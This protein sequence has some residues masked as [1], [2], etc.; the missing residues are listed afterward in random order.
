V[1]LPSFQ[2]YPGDWV[3]DP[4][5]RR[6]SHA[7]KGVWID[8]LCLMHESEQRGVLATAGRAWDDDEIALAVGGDRSTVLACVQE[9]IL[10]G[11]AN[12]QSNGAL[13]SRRLVRDE[14]KRL[15][16]VEAGKRG[17]NPKLVRTLKGEG[18]GES[19]GEAKGEA[20]PKPTPSS[21]SSSSSS[22]KNIKTPPT[23][24]GATLPFDDPGF[25]DLWQR[26]LE[27]LKQKKKPP[28]V[29]AIAMQLNKLC[30]MGLER[31]KTTLRHSIT[32]NWQGLFEPKDDVQNAKNLPLFREHKEERD[33][34]PLVS[35]ETWNQLNEQER[36][37]FQLEPAKWK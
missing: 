3:K 31:A 22:D 36:K 29:N 25:V 21:S 14:Q 23:P 7:A 24:K 37:N 4:N 20:N 27:H 5:L 32:N 16:C 9:L 28:T 15:L 2:F 19:K 34:R 13:Y 33:T 30:D 6:C 11:V 1:K 35:I 12:R 8:L 17:G 18:K 26:W 10:K